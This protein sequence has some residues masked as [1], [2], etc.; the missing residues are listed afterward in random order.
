M[1]QEKRNNQR[2]FSNMQQKK[3]NNQRNFLNTK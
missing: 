2:N 3:R 1:K